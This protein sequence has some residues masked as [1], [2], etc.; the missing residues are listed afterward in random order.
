MSVARPHVPPRFTRMI[1]SPTVFDPAQPDTAHL[2]DL[3][4]GTV[5]LLL[6]STPDREWAAEAALEL[7][8][9]WAGG[10]R[11]IV[12]ADLNLEHPV[13]HE[14]A[15]VDNLEG[16][17]DVFLYGTSLARSAKRVR[18]G[19]FYLIPA[20]TYTA[21]A[22]A[23]FR[24]PRWAKLVAGFEEAGA[25]LLLFAPA[26]A[27]DL[28]L[29]S[30]W[31][32]GVVAL[33]EPHGLTRDQLALGQPPVRAVLTPSEDTT[34]AAATTPPVISS[35]IVS[36]D[37]EDLVLPPAPVR[38]VPQGAR[39]VSVLL[40]VLLGIAVMAVIGFAVARIRPDL[41]PGARSGAQRM[42][43][44]A[45]Q[46]AVV[47]LPTPPT[48]VADSLPYS[49]QAK[50]FASRD[51]AVQQLAADRARLDD[52]PFFIS[53][54][55][56][57][58]VLYFKIFAGTL[59]DTV[60]AN[61]LRERLVTAGLVDPEDALGSWSLI[62]FR[63]L[64]FE[65]GEFPTR[66]AADAA[67]DS[68]RAGEVFA[69]PVPVPYSNGTERWRLYAGAYP[70]SVS[71]GTLREALARAGVTARLVPRVGRAGPSSEEG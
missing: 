18:G 56:D 8:A 12:L 44:L 63:P 34:R 45:P 58:G 55:T 17:V 9:R 61:Q 71:A 32:S 23:V 24:H 59:P 30:A 27:A 60:A 6:V 62:Q 49:V 15:G 25:S 4:G 70:D 26:G 38:E 13:L 20:G 54:E 52:V 14:H 48:A 5:V 29:V 65:V 11:R 19:A 42:E 16:I 53:P 22:E 46:S 31:A 2:P 1:P 3:P 68:L 28:R 41:I 36:A 50:A 43:T 39:A 37:D 67:A 10:G 66:L 57:T 7:S 33:G 64:A 69:Y 51:A 21:D 47:P 40:W 35:K